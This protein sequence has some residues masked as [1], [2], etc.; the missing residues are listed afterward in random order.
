MELNFQPVCSLPTGD[1]T[2]ENPAVKL[3]DH[4]IGDA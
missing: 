1:P 3:T 2:I 4:L